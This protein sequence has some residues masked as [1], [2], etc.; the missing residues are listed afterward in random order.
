MFTIRQAASILWHLLLTRNGIMFWH[1]KK[2]TN[3]G[4]K[5]TGQPNLSSAQ[6]ET[7]LWF[8]GKAYVLEYVGRL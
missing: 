2:K 6:R 1:R 5:P 8:L 3:K 4:T 7:D